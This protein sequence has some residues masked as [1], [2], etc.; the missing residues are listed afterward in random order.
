MSMQRK[1]IIRI[2]EQ[3]FRL[4]NNHLILEQNDGRIL[5]KSSLIR[6][7]LDEY[8]DKTCRDHE[9]MEK[10]EKKPKLTIRAIL[11]QII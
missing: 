7:I 10:L 11:H 5:T 3:Q 2:T 9:L 8:F 1:L 6:G 4:L